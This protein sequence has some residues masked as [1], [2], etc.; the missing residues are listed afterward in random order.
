L[1]EVRPNKKKSISVLARWVIKDKEQFEQFVR[2]LS[3]FVDKLRNLVSDLHMT[4][5]IF[6]TMKADMMD[7][8]I[9][10]SGLRLV[11]DAET[12]ERPEV[13]Q[14]ASER[15][16]EIAQHRILSKLWFASLESRQQAM[17]PQ[18]KNTFEWALGNPA[19]DSSGSE[20]KPAAGSQQ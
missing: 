20:A 3:H 9:D 6:E 10:V 5:T 11:T 18:L 14:A 19:Q 4:K 1:R 12:Q 8:E 15:I 7:A 17:S 2:D 16:K 13:A